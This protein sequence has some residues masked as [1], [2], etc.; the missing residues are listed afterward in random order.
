[1]NMRTEWCGDMYDD[2]LDLSRNVIH[3][4]HLHQ[5]IVDQ[6]SDV[7]PHK[8]ARYPD[9]RHLHETICDVHA[10]DHDQLAVGLGGSEILQRIIKHLSGDVLHVISPTFKMVEI[11]CDMYNVQVKKLQYHDHNMFDM[12]KISDVDTLYLA[13]PN[14]INGHSFTQEQIE[15]ISSKCKMLILDEAYAD[16]DDH[17]HTYTGVDNLMI[18]KTFSK[19]LGFAG[20]RCGY[21]ITHRNNIQRL[22]KYRPAIV[23]TTLATEIIPELIQYLPD[24]INRMI[25]TR[26]MLQRN[27]EHVPSA[28]NYV[29][30]HKKHQHDF[31]KIKHKQFGPWMRMALCDMETLNEHQ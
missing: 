25:R 14:G 19:S 29:L 26:S 1:M 30:I 22:S 23:T 20:A 21:V 31:V 18:V 24:V 5:L 6:L 8:L 10:C 17:Q 2:R 13:N 15:Y 11:Y 12:N 7:D 16:Y 27:Y 3:D 9:E 28:G 4:K